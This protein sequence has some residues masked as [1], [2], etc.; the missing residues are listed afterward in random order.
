VKDAHCT[1]P[2]IRK[3]V[4]EPKDSGRV[5]KLLQFPSTN[6]SSIWSFPIEFGNSCSFSHL[7]TMRKVRVDNSPMVF[8]NLVMVGHPINVR[9]ESWSKFLSVS[10][11]SNTSINT[12]VQCCQIVRFLSTLKYPILAACHSVARSIN[13]LVRLVISPIQGCHGDGRTDTSVRPSVTSDKA[14]VRPLSKYL[15]IFEH[16]RAYSS[17]F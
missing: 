3:L 10:N 14:L 12:L 13:I 5:S 16:I 11:V 17:I 9:L 7:C 8:G 4:N 2:N 15:S 6:D 1:I